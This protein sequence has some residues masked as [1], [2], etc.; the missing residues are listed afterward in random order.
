MAVEK[1][2]KKFRQM[3]GRGVEDPVNIANINYNEASGGTKNMQVGPFLKPI[4]LGAGSYTTDATTA[5]SV[6][7]GT[8]LAIYNHSGTAQAITCG[9]SSAM[10]A[11][12][13]G[14]TDANGNVGIPCLP[15]GWTYLNTYE[16]QFIR[17]NSSNLMVFIIEDET[18]ISSQR[19]G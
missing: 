15:H 6:R 10:A 9:D 5:R 19:Q 8:A 13:H 2:N 1:P 16:K 14:V 12:A 4:K 3:E 11:L 17:T 7:K 18:Y